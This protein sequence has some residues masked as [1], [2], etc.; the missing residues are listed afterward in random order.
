MTD[1]LGWREWV[2]L[3]DLGIDRIKAKIDTGARTSALHGFEVHT[4]TVDGN[5]IV[6][7]KIHPNQK[8]NDSVIECTAPLL[9]EREVK[10][11]GGHAERRYVIETTVE[12]AGKPIKAEVTLTN[13]DEMGFRMLVG[14]TTMNGLFMVDPARSYL[15]GKHKG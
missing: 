2:A 6:R 14:R 4:E 5:D 13:R 12:V 3:P 10:D 7:F 15:T 1:I 11:S 8:D 9:E